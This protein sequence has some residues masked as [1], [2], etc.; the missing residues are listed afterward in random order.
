MPELI[1]PDG[2]RIHYEVFGSGY[3]LLLLAPGG[4]TSQIGS[5]EWG[6]FNPIEEFA[7]EFMVIGMD[8]RHAGQSQAP[9]TPFSYEQMMNDQL[10]VLDHLRL[11][12]AH[13]MGG[14]IGCAYA[15]RLMDE[16]PARI[17]AAV[18][19]DPVGLDDTN[20]MNTFY[21]MFRDTI[22]A[23]RAEGLDA[24]IA[25][26]EENPLFM[27]A[28]TGGPWSQRL[29]DEPEFCNTLRSLRREE[30]IALV[31]D[32]RDG[33]WPAQ[34]PYFSVNDVAVQR[35][36][37]PMLILP[38]SDVFHPTSIAER[39]QST[40]QNAESLGVD[41]R[42]EANLPATIEAVRSF[43]RANVPEAVSAAG[44]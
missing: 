38:G 28:N 35:L 40:A 39:I 17:S 42:S 2:A 19:Q 16:A 21:D 27:Q 43:L 31:V 14:C 24:V 32:F 5:W 26:A 36:T 4:V 20:S 7:D 8:Q 44:G 9:L 12:S 13:F 6:A 29:H 23:T 33:I 30:Y 25:A 11:P 3:P 1:R 22:R 10:A 41:A 15:L 34:P 37:T 18:M